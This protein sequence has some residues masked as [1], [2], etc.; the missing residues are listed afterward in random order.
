MDVSRETGMGPA[1]A[2][3]AAAADQRRHHQIT[4]RLWDGLLAADLATASR[5]LAIITA[6]ANAELAR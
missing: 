4:Q 6:R 1:R 5:V 3:G 2:E